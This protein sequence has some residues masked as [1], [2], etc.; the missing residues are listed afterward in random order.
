MS[1]NI[2][3]TSLVSGRVIEI[4]A[5]LGDT[6]QKGELLLVRRA[7]MSRRPSPDTGARWTSAKLAATQLDR[8]RLLFDKGTLPQKDLEVAEDAD[9]RAKIAVGDFAADQIHVI[10]A[11][12][13]HPT[14]TVDIL[15][16]ASG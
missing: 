11:D 12:V 5:K 10:G 4:G 6:V 8:A 1:R 9:A 16:P 7:Q 2:P 14:S 3:V 13:N 15:A